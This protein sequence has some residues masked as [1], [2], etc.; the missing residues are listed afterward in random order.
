MIVDILF[1]CD[2]AINFFTAYIDR[3]DNL[4]TD[5]NIYIFYLNIN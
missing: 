5:Y 3:E 2:N 4:I 1:L